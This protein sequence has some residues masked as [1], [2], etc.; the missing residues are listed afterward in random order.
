[1]TRAVPLARELL[2]GQWLVAPALNI[3]SSGSRPG[4]LSVK[5]RST[6]GAILNPTGITKAVI[7][8]AVAGEFVFLKGAVCNWLFLLV[9]RKAQEFLEWVPSGVVVLIRVA[10][11]LVRVRVSDQ[12]SELRFGR[13][14][15]GGGNLDQEGLGSTHKQV[16]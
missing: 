10:V 2:R 11:G 9:R 15:A 4:V 1:M 14:C 8:F 3:F 5:R 13:I 12:R 16:C 6:Y 7:K